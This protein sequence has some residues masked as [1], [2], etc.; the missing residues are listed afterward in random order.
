MSHEVPFYRAYLKHA[1]LQG[2]AVINNPFMWDVEDKFL[3]ASLATELGVATPKTVM[4]PHREYAP[5][6]V[7][8]ESLRN[9]EYPL[10]WQAVVD[11]VGLPCVLKPAH[12]GSWKSWRICRSL[13]ELLREYNESGELLTVVQERIEWDHF[14]RC[15]V[16]GQEHVLPM[17]YDPSE[18]R[19]HVHHRHLTDELGLRVVEE[20]LQLVRALGYDMNSI[21]WAIRDGVPYVIDFLNPVPDLDIYTLTPHYFEWAVDHLAATAIRLAREPRPQPQPEV[22]GW[23]LGDRSRQRVA[24]PVAGPAAAHDE[25]GDLAEELP[26]LARDLPHSALL[27]HDEPAE[28]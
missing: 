12:R 5:G 4:L 3:G 2:V 7:H 10:D 1:A 17:K 24:T 25:A 27:P 26:S 28:D 9:L 16:L 22:S 14:V 6:I 8:Q 11:H 23:F 20:S 15:L 21:D 19:Y 18:R 13:D